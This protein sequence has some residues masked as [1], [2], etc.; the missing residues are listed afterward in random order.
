MAYTIKPV[1]DFKR[2]LNR[3]L[4]EN[5]IELD[6]EKAL[7]NN[8]TSSNLSDL[9]KLLLNL[10]N[11]ELDETSYTKLK[12]LLQNN[13][14]IDPNMIFSL[15]EN[16]SM[17][18]SKENIQFL[19]NLIKDKY[20]QYISSPS[21]I[22][23]DEMY[24]LTV[25]VNKV[26][27]DVFLDLVKEP[28]SNIKQQQN[29]IK[30]KVL[31]TINHWSSH[32]T[33][34]AEEEN[35]DIAAALYITSRKL[36]PH[37]SIYIPGRI[38]SMK[39]SISNISKE[40]QKG[41]SNIIPEDLSAGISDDDVKEQFSL[42]NAN[43]DFSG[44][45][46]V[47]SNTD[48]ILHFDTSDPKSAEILK[49]RKIRKDNISF[50]HCLENFLSENEDTYF[51]NTELLQI[52]IDLLTKLRESTYAECT[53]EFQ[54]TSFTKIL[55][56]TIEQYNNEIENP[57]INQIS[58]D[59]SIYILELDEIDTL[60]EELKKRVHDKY[61]AKL[62]ETV[63]PEI[64]QD[65]IFT[66][67][68]KVQSTFLKNVKKKNGFCSSYYLL[69]TASGRRIEL[70][71]QSK[72]RFKDSKDGSSD[73]SLLPNK[74]INISHFF[75]PSNDD[76]DNEQFE[77]FLHLLSTTPITTK[78]FLYN[79]SDSVL[80]PREKRLKRKLKIAEQNVK[81]KDSYTIE[82]KNSDGSNKLIEIPVETYLPMF[83]EYISPKLMSVSSHHTRFNKSVAK[84]DKKSLVS[85]F[86]EVLLK[87][88]S[89]TCLAQILIDKLE[90]IIPNE[91]NEVTQNGINIRAASRLANN[92]DTDSI[93]L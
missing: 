7:I 68:L 28:N 90:S 1:E 40:F 10:E 3:Y 92:Q 84:Y 9:Y 20:L 64:L 82:T 76:S 16:S 34:E 18:I 21:D 67:T 47:L 39:S 75:M 71:V 54:G 29:Y 70:Q 60:L 65:E 33:K 4:A 87:Q 36:Y 88:D 42:K 13:F 11:I 86:I 59:D 69:K 24:N 51:S 12:E 2:D 57:D 26:F 48:D 6:Y 14:E 22:N 15:N 44:F 79:T 77:T 49:L 5:P 50:I 91:K 27:P 37:L 78:N 61:Q 25:I 74:R 35:R 52:K 30:E 58:D 85:G 32:N 8:F 72:M 53:Q 73:H 56:K 19:E 45:T 55:K 23:Q 62:L 46:I 89:T 81:L 83:A 93:E 66:D 31:A 80:S 63:I 38:K 43:N 41:I 17:S